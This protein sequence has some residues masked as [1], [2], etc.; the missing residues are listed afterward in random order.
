MSASDELH[1]L[2]ASLDKATTALSDAAARLEAL[3]AG[4]KATV[5]TRRW[6]RRDTAVA[7]ASSLGTAIVLALVGVAWPSAK[8]EPAPV[9]ATVAPKA[10]E[11][12][13]RSEPIPPPPPEP[14][15]V[16][17]AP[18]PVEPPAPPP[19][20]KPV[21]VKP[22]VAKQPAPPPAPLDPNPYSTPRRHEA[23]DVF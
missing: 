14:V 12:P 10:P 17:K 21:V 3:E 8:P 1:E 4:G 15:V 22:V 6:R 9:V 23:S 20:V 2:R 13:I 5:I 19:V 16:V 7:A 11:P 18:E